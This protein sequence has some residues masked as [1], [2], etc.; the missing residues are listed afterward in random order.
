MKDEGLGDWRIA[1]ASRL[2]KDANFETIG[3]TS[4]S[5]GTPVYVAHLAQSIKDGGLSF[6][7]PHPV[8]LN[9]EIAFNSVIEAT[10][11]KKT[12]GLHQNRKGKIRETHIDD[13]QQL[14]D[15]FQFC[16]VAI[17]FSYQAIETFINFVLSRKVNTPLSYEHKGIAHLITPEE[18]EKKYSTDEKIKLFLPQVTGIQIDS[19]SLLWN[20]F[21]ALKRDRDAIVHIKYEDMFTRGE[22]KPIETSLFT[23]LWKEKMMDHLHTSYNMI[24]HFRDD[25][26][27]ERW[28]EYFEEKLADLQR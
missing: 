18:I 16:F 15:Y 6:I 20:K 28:Q 8:A 4:H 12:I 10:K 19:K 3:G 1:V 23:R 7:T 21:V 5:A 27:R 13:T 2:A 17:I 11:I 9:L 26:T 24:N 14:F 25:S 22:I